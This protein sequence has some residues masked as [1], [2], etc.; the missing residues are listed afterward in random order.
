MWPRRST[1]RRLAAAGHCRHIA[2]LRRLLTIQAVKELKERVAEF[3]RL[4]QEMRATSPGSLK[5]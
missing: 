5:P 3:E 2:D 1:G 4:I